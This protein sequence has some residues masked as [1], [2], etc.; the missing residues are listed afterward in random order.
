LNPKAVRITIPLLF[1]HMAVVCS[2]L[3]L[4]PEL[5]WQ[6]PFVP[7]LEGQYIMKNLVVIALAFGVAA[8]TK[9]WMKPAG[10]GSA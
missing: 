7:T 4:V 2:P 8:N 10:K 9:P 5:T 3:I 6:Q 1:I